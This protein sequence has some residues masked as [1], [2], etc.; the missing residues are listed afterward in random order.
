[1]NQF[2]AHF[3]LKF[4]VCHTFWQIT[5]KDLLTL[6]VLSDRKKLLAQANAD[7]R[8]NLVYFFYKVSI[9]A[10]SAFTLFGLLCYLSNADLFSLI[11][12]PRVIKSNKLLIH[13]FVCL[14]FLQLY[15]FFAFSLKLECEKLAQ[16]KTEIQRQYIMYYE[17]SYGLNVEMH[18]QV[19]F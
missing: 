7:S 17:M 9:Y 15:F 5:F 2:F 14:K 3:L 18:K 6:F 4:F 16:E 10:W 1:M 19:R 8:N 12:A 13:F 11:F